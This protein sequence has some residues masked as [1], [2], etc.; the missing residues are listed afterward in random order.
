MLGMLATLFGSAVWMFT[1]T[2]LR[3]PVSTTH[4]MVGSTIGF[5]LVSKAGADG[6]KFEV[7]GN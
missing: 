7:L 3:L 4:S 6:I 1:A 2:Y 5:T